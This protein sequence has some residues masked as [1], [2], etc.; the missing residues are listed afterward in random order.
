MSS[1]SSH[2]SR[3]QFLLNQIDEIGP[4]VAIENVVWTVFATPILVFLQST[5]GE[6]IAFQQSS[7]QSS[8]IFHRSLAKVDIISSGE[9]N[10]DADRRA[11]SFA[12]AITSVP[13]VAKDRSEQLSLDRAD[14]EE[15]RLTYYRVRDEELP[16]HRQHSEM[17]CI[18]CLVDYSNKLPRCVLMPCLL[19][20]EW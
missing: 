19:C 2:I 14:R 16:C 4:S 17:R 18:D 11:V 20:C 9:S 5:G 10:F 15:M 7:S 1:S 13:T 6:S 3:V 8:T 12:T